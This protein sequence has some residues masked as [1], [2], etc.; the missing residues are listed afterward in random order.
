VKFDFV[1]WT[2]YNRPPF[3]PEWLCRGET[4]EQT[5]YDDAL[6]ESVNR[7]IGALAELYDID[8]ASGVNL[9]RLGKIAGEERNGKS[10]GLYRVYIRL[11]V[12]TNNSADTINDIIN[13][14]GYIYNPIDI[15]ILPEYPAGIKVYHDGWR[16]SDFRFKDI[17]RSV[18]PAGVGYE[19]IEFFLIIEELL[20]HDEHSE[21]FASLFHTDIAAPVLETIRAYGSLYLADRA[22]LHDTGNRQFYNGVYRH[23]G[24]I[25]YGNSDELWDKQGYHA[26][27]DT[28]TVTDIDPNEYFTS[29][30]H[31][32]TVR[33]ILESITGSAAR[34]A[35]DNAVVTDGALSGSGTHTLSDT[36][37]AV[38]TAPAGKTSLAA[39]SD[40]FVFMYDGS[41]THNGRTT[42]RGT[43]DG[44]AISVRRNGTLISTEGV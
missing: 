4:L 35:A 40:S 33:Q 44:M 42:Y 19:I 12:I 9:D 6:L 36:V 14:I 5:R 1:D 41:I 38:D 3:F 11:R 17:V 7:G 32:D 26:Q 27:S 16:E 30:F 2:T 20:W 22:P 37:T 31:T 8:G 29:L 24:V 15:H 34:R 39:F 43:F 10:D 23:D 21:F 25:F 28:V 13:A 18:I